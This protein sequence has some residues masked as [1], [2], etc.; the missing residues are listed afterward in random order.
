MA[1][2]ERKLNKKMIERLII[3]H[4][5]IKSGQYPNNARMRNHYRVQTGYEV[6]EAT[7]NRDIDTL[8]VYFKAPLEYDRSRGGYYYTD[9]WEFALNSFTGKDLFYL[10][11]AKTLLSAFAGTPMYNGISEV[12]DFITNTQSEGKSSLLDRIA[13]PPTPKI[14]IDEA[15]WQNVTSALRDNL[16][17]EFDYNGRWNP[18]D[19]HRRVRPYQILLDDGRCFL[20]GY[21]EERNAERIFALSRMKNVK[22]TDE[23]FALPDDY[24]F[25]ARCGGGKFGVFMGGKCEQFVIDFYGEA[26]A[27]IRECLWADDQTITEYDD[28]DKTRLSFRATQFLKVKEL[29]L[30][31]GANAVPIEP[32][33]F[34]GDWA[35]TVKAMSMRSEQLSMSK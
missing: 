29:I 16:I 2:N 13:T 24:E 1:D 6:G 28:E 5:L 17:L 22:V 25:A 7:I 19:S 9:D 20:F 23:H 27:Y 3:I 34:V 30:S 4:N 21:S 8:R 12:I 26:R 11:A 31:Q 10:A 33:W 18:Q 35:D 14:V 32:A 15:I